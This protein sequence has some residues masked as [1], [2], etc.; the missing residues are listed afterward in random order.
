[1]QKK[2]ILIIF[3]V[4]NFLLLCIM[5]ITC[6]FTFRFKKSIS[7]SIDSA[8]ENNYVP[9]AVANG[10]EH[11]FCTTSTVLEEYHS[12]GGDVVINNNISAIGASAFNGVRLGAID[13]IITSVYIPDTVTWIGR[14]AFF[15]TTAKT[16]RL[17]GELLYIG[18]WAFAESTALEKVYFEVVPRHDII[19]DESAFYGCPNVEL[20]NFPDDISLDENGYIV[21]K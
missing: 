1:M 15:A 10:D 4:I 12:P 20:V 18:E 19:I 21:R 9:Y 5:I 13:T 16:I 7:E 14:H 8:S 6:I 11:A 2:Q 3:T 17:S